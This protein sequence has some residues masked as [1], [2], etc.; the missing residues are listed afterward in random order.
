MKILVPIDGSQY[1]LEAL[2][3][4]KSIAEKFSGE[5]MVV[6]IQRRLVSRP[7][8]TEFD[9]SEFIEDNPDILRE[10]GERVLKKGLEALKGSSLK[11]ETCILMGDPADQI[12]ECAKESKAD[13]IVMGSLGLT[14]ITRFLMGSVSTKVVN[15]AD[16][17]VMVVKKPG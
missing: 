17:P 1:S 16:I 10:R 7:K 3:M 9:V 11:V 4:A 2:N 6:N 5:L 8:S 15:H 12:L 14:G 13:M